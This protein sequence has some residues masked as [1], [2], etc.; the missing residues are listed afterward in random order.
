MNMRTLG[1][2]EIEALA[3][4]ESVPRFDA[5]I[6][7]VWDQR[8]GESEYGTWYLQNIVVGID[9]GELVVTWTGEDEFDKH[10]TGKLVAFECGENAKGKLVG[11]M[12]DIRTAKDGTVY[13]GVKVTPAG[14]MRLLA[15]S[16]LAPEPP[17]PPNGA[18]DKAPAPAAESPPVT[19]T[20]ER[21]DEYAKHSRRVFFAAWSAAEDAMNWMIGKEAEKMTVAERYDLQLRVAQGIA[22]EINKTLRKERF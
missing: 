12:R 17:P 2:K 22:I 15:E 18:P 21:L 7:K 19:S 10:W 5:K 20:D 8:S 13:K 9:G 1:L 4:C 11:V 3:H 6:K 16:G 14:K